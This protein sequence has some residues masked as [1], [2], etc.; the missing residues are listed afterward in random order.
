MSLFALLVYLCLCGAS[1]GDSLVAA[2]GRDLRR[3]GLL[4]ETRRDASTPLCCRRPR[5]PWSPPHPGSGDGPSPV[6]VSAGRDAL[7]LTVTT[8]PVALPWLAR[9]WAVTGNPVFPAANALFG[10]RGWTGAQAE[11]LA[12]DAHAAADMIRSWRDVL[13]LPFDLVA[14]SHD[15]GA[16]SPSLWFWPLVVLAGA[17]VLLVERPGRKE[18]LLLG[19]VAG[20]CLLWS[21]TFLMARF[22]LPAMALGAIVAA[23]ALER[24]HRPPAAGD[25][26]GCWQGCCWRPTP[27]SCTGTGR[28]A[29]RFPR[30]WG[31]RRA[32]TT[33]GRCSAPGRHSRW[34]IA[35]CRRRRGS[36]SWASRGPPGSSGITSPPRPSTRPCCRRSCAGGGPRP[37][38]RRPARPRHHPRSGQRS[39]VAAVGAR[40]PGHRHGPGTP[41]CLPQVSRHRLPP[42]LRR[43]R[44]PPLR[45]PRRI[46]GLTSRAID[47]YMCMYA[48]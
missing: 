22:L 27:S 9:N 7:L 45:A 12:L 4:G 28:P 41:G 21:V 16:A 11:L 18:R 3:P 8:V 37:L 30:P 10:G 32:P 13:R 36:W 42:P 35:T 2:A 31:S 43:Q 23:V 15:F 47:L 39:R 14:S 25:P 44:G 40:L 17:S 48:Y 46:I 24:V 29:M 34:S 26:A 1:T 5:W 6:A 33:S 19:L 38:R 20:S